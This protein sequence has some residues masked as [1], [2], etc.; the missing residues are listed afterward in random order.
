MGNKF[1]LID[2]NEKELKEINGGFLMSIISL[3]MT[4]V[5]KAVDL[6]KGLNDGYQSAT[7]S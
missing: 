1:G 2:L 4:S 7:K 3:F 5:E 6:I